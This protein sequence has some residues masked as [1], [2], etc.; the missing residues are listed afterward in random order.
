MTTS[1]AWLPPLALA[2]TAG[3]LAG[4]LGSSRPVAAQAPRAPSLD[5]GRLVWR[6]PPPVGLGQ[7]LLVVEVRATWCAACRARFPLLRRLP[8]AWGRRR[9]A[10][11]EAATGSTAAPASAPDHRLSLW[12]CRTMLT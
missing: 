6:G 10:G 11:G 7:R 2:L 8:R 1:A 5:G 12:S 3:L 9:P 4:L